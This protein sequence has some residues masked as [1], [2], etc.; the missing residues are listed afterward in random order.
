MTSLP[1]EPNPQATTPLPR[2]PAPLWNAP[3]VG[4]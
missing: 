4:L 2:E 3:R 1:G